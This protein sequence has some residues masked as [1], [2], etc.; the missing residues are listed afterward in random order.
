MGF[1]GTCSVDC[2]GRRGDFD[3]YVEKLVINSPD[4]GAVKLSR[5]LRRGWIGC[6]VTRIGYELTTYD[7]SPFFFHSTVVEDQWASSGYIQFKLKAMSDN[8]KSWS[9]KICQNH[10]KRLERN[11]TRL[12]RLKYRQDNDGIELFNSLSREFEN[13][14]LKKEVYWKQRAKCNW[15]AEGDANTRFFHNVASTRQRRNKVRRL[16]DEQSEW[17]SLRQG[18]HNIYRRYYTDLFADSGEQ[19]T[20]YFHV[21][22]RV[23]D[24]HNDIMISPVSYLE[25]K[26]VVFSMHNDKSSGPYGFN[27]SFYKKYRRVVGSDVVKACKLFFETGCLL[28]GLNN[29]TIVLIPK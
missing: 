15:L 23:D 13:L 9:S 21:D 5:R 25:V 7:H 3:S 17:C 26:N 4:S 28:E 18:N 22:S 12:Q 6:V 11:R 19:F 20:D 2:V 1:K 29:M 14:L 24:G 8:L 10:K 27:P 16:K